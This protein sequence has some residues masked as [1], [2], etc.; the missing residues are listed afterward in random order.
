MFT[1]ILELDLLELSSTLVLSETFPTVKD[2]PELSP[3]S[4]ELLSLLSL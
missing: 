4:S 1:I 3:E 2:P